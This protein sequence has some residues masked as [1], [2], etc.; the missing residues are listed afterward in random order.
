MRPRRQDH[1][2]ALH[3]RSGLRSQSVDGGDVQLGWL[4]VGFLTRQRRST[5]QGSRG[6][7]KARLELQRRP[8]YNA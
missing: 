2:S 1:G 3:P 4:E 7:E 6:E 5:V 8:S